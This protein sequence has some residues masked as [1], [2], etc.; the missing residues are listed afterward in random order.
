MANQM[1]ALQ[2]RNPQLPD[3]SRQNAQFANM[4]NMVRQ[5]EVAQR[6]AAQ[7]QQAMTI[8]AAEEARAVRMAKPQLAE[9]E[10]KATGADIKTKLEFQ[11][12]VYTAL[13][14]ADSPDQVAG[15][16]ERIARQPQFQDDL[17][18]G[19]LADAVASMPTD[20]AQFDAWRQTTAAKTLTGAQQ[21][22][23]EFTSQNLG[24]STRLLRTPK[25][26]GGGAEVVE[27]SEAAV[28]IKPTVVNTDELGPIIVDP[29]TGKGYPVSAGAIGGYTAPGVGGSRGVA[30]GGT[31]DVVFGFGKFGSPSKPLSTL[32]IGEV[33]DFQRN[34]LIPNTRGK[35]GAGP[36]KG[37]GAVGTYQITYGTLQDYAPKVLGANWRDKPFT[38]DVQERIAKA[39][40]NDV[41][42]GDLKDTWAGLPSNRPGQYKNVPW[43]QVRDQ[44]IQVESAGGPRRGGG[45]PTGAGAPQTIRQVASAADKART[46]KQFKEITGF[47]F[48]SGKDPVADLIRRSTSGGAEKLGA[49]IV[50]F[51]P[52]SMGGGATK[53]M[54]AIGALEVI[55]SDLTLA[56]LPGNKLGAGVS[57]EDRKM[58]EKLV[59]EM[60]NPN[61]PTGKRLAAWGQL[62]ARMGRIFGV[63]EPK[64][65]AAPATGAAKTPV[66]PDAAKQ[67]LR[68][69]PSPQQRAFFDRTFGKG[70]AAKV[71]G[72]R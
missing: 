45:T 1:I 15:F 17:F 34:T 36:G 55:A 26:G 72:V 13:K 68:K 40:Y 54:E 12:F 28:D 71:L 18:Q 62:K 2:A 49:D 56:L 50:G 58:F 14:N 24:T 65:S 43:E 8:A 57:N 51:I 63:A 21:L 30:G 53:G 6:Q 7:A 9:A 41:K 22:E 27:G 61:I 10:S 69:N 67:M 11:A 25:F 66:I 47:D 23:Q 16:A 37:T 32:S 29:N 5:S 38:A 48:T 70:A 35:V 59:G 39:I 31:E 19:A 60:Q 44:I 46:V 52:E 42:G 64:T 3:P 4:M 20:P 33:Q